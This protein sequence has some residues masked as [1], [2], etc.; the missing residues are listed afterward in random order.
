MVFL[1][2]MNNYFDVLK[3][4]I[5]AG[6]AI[7]FGCIAFLTMGNLIGPILFTF[8]LITVVHY[9]LSL[10]TGSVGFFELL[11]FNKT[12]SNNW[13]TILAIILG[14]IIGCLVV[15]LL[16]SYGNFT[17]TILAN[18]VVQSRLAQPIVSVVI[19]AMGCGLIMSTAVQF[20]REGK[21]LPLLFGVPLFIYCG[22]YHS[23]ADT[24]YYLFSNLK[25]TF[26]MVYTLFMTYF[27]N[28]LGCSAYKLFLKI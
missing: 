25:P 11:G 28:Y 14:N 9:K 16:A 7:S 19:R 4:A 8:G 3:K 12:I 1:K 27:G 5:F 2:K 10:Y 18:D 15:A 24:F 20:A 6:I 22:F 17:F 13:K 21:F 26:I 23:I